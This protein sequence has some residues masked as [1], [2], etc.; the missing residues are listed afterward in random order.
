MALTH[1]RD[2]WSVTLEGVLADDQDDVAEANDELETSGYA[3]VNLR[4]S[5]QVLD[6]LALVAGVENLFDKRYREH[7]G[8]F[9]RVQNRDIRLGERLPGVGRNFFATVHYSF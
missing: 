4:G 6:G 2:T 1:E 8:G 5:W 7:L 3:I 9:N